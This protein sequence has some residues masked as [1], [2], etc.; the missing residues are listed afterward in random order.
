MKSFT[1]IKN[2]LWCPLV[3]ACIQ[4]FVIMTIFM[5]FFEIKDHYYASISNAGIKK[6]IEKRINQCGKDYWLSWIVLD[7]N[8]SKR[9]YYFQDVIGCNPESGIKNDCSFSV[10]NSKLNPFYNETYH[11]LDKNTYK[12]LMGM[13]TG[14]VGYYDNLTKLRTYKAMNEALNSFNKEIKVLGLT[15][16]KNIKQNIVYVFAMTKTGD[17]KMTCNKSDIINILEDLSIYAKEKL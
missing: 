5:Q 7:G 10:K 8:V 13:D 3:S 2:K 15:V 4:I 14:L 12:L 9:K 16:T 11:K 6:K 17:S 1:K